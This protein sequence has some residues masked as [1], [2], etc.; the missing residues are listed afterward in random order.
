MQEIRLIEV[1]EKSVVL[2]VIT[3]AWSFLAFTTLHAYLQSKWYPF[4]LLAFGVICLL[5]IFIQGV[6]ELYNTYNDQLFLKYGTIKGG[7]IAV[8]IAYLILLPPIYTLTSIF[9]K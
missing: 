3:I 9:P 4:V 8:A 2:G 7:L 1:L 6:L 5:F